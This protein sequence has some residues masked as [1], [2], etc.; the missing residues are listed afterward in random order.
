[1]TWHRRGWIFA[2]VLLALGTAWTFHELWASHAMFVHENTWRDVPTYRDMAEGLVP[3]EGPTTSIGG[4]HGVIG[5]WIYGGV[6]TLWP[7]FD[8]LW[9]GSVVLYLLTGL[10]MAAVCR[11]VASPMATA[12][13]VAVLASTNLFLV[14]QFPSHIMYLPLGASMLLLGLL[15]ARDHAVWAWV[16]GLGVLLSVGSH[17]S[18]WL[19][20]IVAF[21]FDRLGDRSLF[22]PSRWVAWTPLLVY[23][24]GAAWVSS[25][26]GTPP[27]ERTVSGV[28]EQLM[29]M[30][31]HK[32][33]LQA[34]FFHFRFAMWP[35]IQLPQ[36]A[37]VVGSGWLA[38]KAA[39]RGERP[40]DGGP[41]TLLAFYGVWFVGLLFYSYDTHY[42]MPMLAALPAVLALGFDTIAARHPNRLVAAGWG[43]VGLHLVSAAI[44]QGFAVYVVDLPQSDMQSLT[45]RLAVVEQLDDLGVSEE[46]VYTDTFFEGRADGRRLAWIHRA[47]STALGTTGRG[48]CVRIVSA[49]AP[50]SEPPPEQVRPAGRWRVELRPAPDAGA[51]ESNVEVA[52]AVIWWRRVSDGAVFLRRT[53]DW[54]PPE[55]EPVAP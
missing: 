24:L 13:G 48:P 31:P 53:G 38:W 27:P 33:L 18:G 19:L 9:A 55:V 21:V 34:P 54:A 41:R 44:V 37:V 45:D 46:A 23:V 25:W 22:K 47:F 8:G 26:E 52:G 39:P 11:Q 3:V 28:L 10:A 14:P 43:L 6:M 5:T 7:T 16:A 30:V 15:R 32:V 50:V 42:I 29:A 12:L 40:L 35:W 17:R 4:R 49:E 1:M 51:C 2:L 20:L 36:L